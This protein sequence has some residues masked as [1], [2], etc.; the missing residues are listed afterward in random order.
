MC[1]V[2]TFLQYHF[3]KKKSNSTLEALAKAV[4]QEKEIYPKT[5]KEK[6]ISIV[7]LSIFFVL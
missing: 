7:L 3:F 5:R 2:L 1:V 6:T 4:T